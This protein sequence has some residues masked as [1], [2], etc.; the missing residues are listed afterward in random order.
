MDLPTLFIKTLTRDGT[1]FPDSRISRNVLTGALGCWARYL[2]IAG[3]VSNT[4]PS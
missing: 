2:L 4:L 1:T 3:S